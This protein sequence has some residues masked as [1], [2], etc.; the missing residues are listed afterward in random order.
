MMMDCTAN[1]VDT[2]RLLPMDLDKLQLERKSDQ[3]WALARRDMPLFEKFFNDEASELEATQVAVISIQL[4]ATE[5]YVYRNEI[6][7]IGDQLL[8][9]Y[10]DEINSGYIDTLAFVNKQI[11]RIKN[12]IIDIGKTEETREEVEQNLESIRESIA[13]T[14][15][16]TLFNINKYRDIIFR[17]Y[18]GQFGESGYDEIVT[19][20]E[21]AVIAR[22]QVLAHLLLL[23]KD[24]EIQS[25]DGSWFK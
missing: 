13:E 21:Q 22:C 4:I 17:M 11:N 6:E 3:I 9:I 20:A 14:R 19:E 2:F 7:N 10:R 16:I 12:K 1:D 18:A 8:D 5:L 23:L 24:V 15:L 25:L